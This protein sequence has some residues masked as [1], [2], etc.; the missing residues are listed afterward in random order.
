MLETGNDFILEMVSSDTGTGQFPLCFQPIEENLI[1]KKIVETKSRLLIFSAFDERIDRYR[2][3]AV[4]GAV[5][6]ILNRLPFGGFECPE[7]FYCFDH[8]ALTEIQFIG[9]K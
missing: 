3:K 5:E 1:G 6:I 4:R 7:F 8:E 9:L 2:W